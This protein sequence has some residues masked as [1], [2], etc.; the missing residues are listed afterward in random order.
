M[1]SQRAPHLVF[2]THIQEALSQYIVDLF[3][4]QSP[5]QEKITGTTADKGLPQIDLR[6]E[7]GWMLYFLTRL[8]GAKKAV[9][10]GTLAGYSAS[11]IAQALPDD[12]KLITLE[13]NAHH[14]QVA[15]DNLTAAGLAHKV[16]ILLGN[17]H[18]NLKTL[19][20]APFDL[21]FLDA[22]KT[23]YPRYLLWAVEHVRQGGLIIAHN[24]FQHAAILDTSQDRDS[25]VRAMQ[26]FNERVAQDPR[27]LSTI[28]P[29]G[30]GLLVAMVK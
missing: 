22:D 30:D 24:A 12:G 1:S 20:G 2:E 8:V 17:A 19:D 5:L 28:I 14:A 23:G 4:R 11:W 13:V 29:V 26:E 27:L 16:H 25:N 7:E 3:V 18:E 15:Q 10:I 6:A 9:E 21:V